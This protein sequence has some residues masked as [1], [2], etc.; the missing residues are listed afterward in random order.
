M[1]NGIQ[2]ASNW[3]FK[4]A[5]YWRLKLASCSHLNP[6]ARNLAN[7]RIHRNPKCGNGAYSARLDL[8]GF[9]IVSRRV[10]MTI[11]GDWAVFG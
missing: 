6:A 3:R 2:D 8:F 1:R 11:E 9:H 10:A 5:G 4:P 7:H